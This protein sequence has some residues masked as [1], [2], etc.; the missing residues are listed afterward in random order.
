MIL[1]Q[2]IFGCLLSIVCS[3]PL[4]LVAD[5]RV[6]PLIY[7]HLNL[8]PPIGDMTGYVTWYDPGLCPPGE[9][10]VQ[11]NGDG[12]FGLGGNVDPLLWGHNMLA[13]DPSL[14]GAGI[15]III[16]GVEY[17][18]YCGDSFGIFPNGDPVPTIFYSEK[19]DTWFVRFDLYWPVSLYGKPE[20]GIVYVNDWFV[21]KMFNEGPDWLEE[22]GNIP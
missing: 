19:H 13:C 4:D 11:G 1:I 22:T 20:W 12:R 7:S 14:Y 5:P 3:T 18:A 17:R 21:F 16:F 6:P 15:H 10:C 9:P 2:V 8:P